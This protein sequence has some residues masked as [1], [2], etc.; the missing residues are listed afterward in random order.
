MEC[1]NLQQLGIATPMSFFF[2]SYSLQEPPKGTS[3][4]DQICLDSL[5]CAA[6]ALFTF[7]MVLRQLLSE[8]LLKR[9]SESQSICGFAAIYVGV[10]PSFATEMTG[11]QGF[12]A[13]V[14]KRQPSSGPL[15]RPSECGMHTRAIKYPNI[16]CQKY[17]AKV[18]CHALWSRHQGCR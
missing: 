3:G 11:S 7:A 4:S 13:V 6:R 9:P 12:L 10:E 17:V 8:R 2:H 15:G 1:R 18:C 5:S 16:Q 14:C